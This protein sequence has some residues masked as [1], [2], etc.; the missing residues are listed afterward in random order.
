MTKFERLEFLGVTA[1]MLVS[2]QDFSRAVKS[3]SK[4]RA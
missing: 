4:I 1:F 2:G 3:P